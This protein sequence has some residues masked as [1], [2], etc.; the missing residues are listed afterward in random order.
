MSKLQIIIIIVFVLAAL[1][2]VL[3]FSGI[4]PGFGGGGGGGKVPDVSLWGTFPEAKI[5][6]VISEFNKNNKDYFQIKY[7]EKKPAQYESEIINALASGAGPDI[8]ILTQDLVLR[9]KDKVFTLP[10]EYYKE[11]DFRDNFIDSS[12][13]FINSRDKTIIGLPLAVDPI[14]LYWNRDLFAAAGIS[15]PPRYW[16]E[17]LIDVE[18]LAQKDGAGN[19]V[20]AGVALGEFYNVKNAK[21]I[22]SMLILQTGNPI[23]KSD[24]LQVLFG[25]RG[26]SLI[27]PTE[28]TVR[29]FTEFSN[30]S[31]SSY[32]WNR[33]LPESDKMFVAGSLAMYFGF[34]SEVENI[35]QKNPHLNFDI[36]EVPQIRD[37]KSKACFGK[38]YSLVV[39][40]N[41]R[42]T[43]EAVGVILALTN[44]DFSKG[45]SE[46]TGLGSPR[47]DILAEKKSDPVLSVVYKSTLI[48]KA[49]LEPNPEKVS[50]IFKNMVES[51]VTGRLRISEAVRNTQTQLGQ[52][53]K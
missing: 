29:F 8:W 10:L 4:L 43:Q 51:V 5:R 13:L 18:N 24:T 35:K 31:K 17:F 15:Q 20:Q 42:Q 12:E 45:F 14:V 53:I 27:S 48:A 22:L 40:K 7:F 33:A 32:T 30:P 11:R 39:S 19:I 25:E 3:I 21:E 36:A 2:A 1:I 38:I 23:I 52:L 46:V 28:N 16:D 50:E 6:N 44:K 37:S 47:R 34:A 9:N 26:D 49:W 41:S